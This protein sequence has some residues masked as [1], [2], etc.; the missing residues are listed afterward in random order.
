MLP[1]HADREADVDRK[2]V[3]QKGEEDLKWSRE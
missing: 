3:Q 1:F 2:G